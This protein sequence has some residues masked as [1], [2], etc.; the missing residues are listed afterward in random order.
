MY[1]YIYM[2]S[3][4]TNLKHDSEEALYEKLRQLLAIVMIE[5]CNN[6]ILEAR[7]GFVLACR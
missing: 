4:W 2:H 3:Q 6:N 5:E 7:G 1:I